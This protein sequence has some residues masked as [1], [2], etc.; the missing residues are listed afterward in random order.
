MKITKKDDS[1]N[2]LSIPFR[3]E[4]LTVI[5]LFSFFFASS[6]QSEPIVVIVHP[7][8]K[9]ESIDLSLAKRIFLGKKKNYKGVNLRVVDV[10]EENIRKD[11]YQEIADLSLP[12][13]RKYWAK[14]IFTGKGNPPKKVAS[15][16]TAKRMVSKSK[17]SI[18]FIEK[19]KVDANVKVI[20]EIN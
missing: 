2:L 18:S 5:F 10:K 19:S 12:K 14:R 1:F 11:F 3:K 20:L 9:I 16:T 8:S 17:S 4:F 7:D 6:A 13:L 15:T